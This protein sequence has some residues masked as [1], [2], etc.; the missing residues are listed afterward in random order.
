M[1][2]LSL[3][4]YLATGE[5]TAAE[6]QLTL[7]KAL[8][9]LPLEQ[10]VPADVELTAAE[11]AEGHALLDSVVH[12]WEAL[13]GSSP[14]ALRFEFLMRPGTLA[15]DVDGGWLIRVESR[16]ADILLDQLPWGISMFQLP[17][18]SHLTRVEWR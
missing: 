18:M 11:L 12:H 6:H 2:A 4:H 13:R 14:E 15:T 3:L 17:W 9:E 7:P 8:C 10:P 5:L 16:T 1:R